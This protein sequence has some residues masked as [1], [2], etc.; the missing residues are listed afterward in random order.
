MAGA[1]KVLGAEKSSGNG[2]DGRG[3]VL[4]GAVSIRQIV[5]L[6]PLIL[7][8][9]KEVIQLHLTLDFIAQ[10]QNI[11]GPQVKL[12]KS[13]PFC[14]NLY[15]QSCDLTISQKLG[16]CGRWVSFAAQLT[17]D[18]GVTQGCTDHVV[19]IRAE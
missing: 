10:L 1:E 9:H 4:M 3:K 14:L 7:L 19:V 16:I 18:L 13:K 2:R 6:Q 17:S 8:Q 15:L 5:S 11:G 12:Y